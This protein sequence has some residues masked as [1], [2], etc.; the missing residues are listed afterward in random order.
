MT[1][2]QRINKAI[3]LFEQAD[4]MCGEALRLLHSA[5]YCRLAAE[6]ATDAQYQLMD[7]VT[8]LQTR[9]LRRKKKLKKVS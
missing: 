9:P 8:H 2:D 4:D 5:T 7:A 3:S 1:T 6:H